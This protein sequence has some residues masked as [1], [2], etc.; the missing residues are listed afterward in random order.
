MSKKITFGIIIIFII[1]SCINAPKYAYDGGALILQHLGTV[2]LLVPLIMDLKVSH[3]DYQIKPITYICYVSFICLHIIGARY[4]YSNVPY[5]VWAKKIF[6][7]NILTDG[8]VHGNKYDRLVHFAFGL[9]AMPL[10]IHYSKRLI[11]SDRLLSVM[12]FA[13]CVIQ[14]LSMMYEIFEWFLSYIL[15]EEGT[16]GYN[17]QQG[18]NWDAQKDMMLALI[19]SSI[20]SLIYFFHKKVKGSK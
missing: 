2:L 7:L 10:S 1:I 9:L 14:T 13:W 4:L 18:D 6:N 11:K 15:S 12:L 17:G 5:D 8:I 19:G 16:E 20:S 3:V